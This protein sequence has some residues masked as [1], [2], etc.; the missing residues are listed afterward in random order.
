MP[1]IAPIAAEPCF[2]DSEEDI[3]FGDEVTPPGRESVE[4]VVPVVPIVAPKRPKGR[5]RKPRALQTDAV[6]DEVEIASIVLHKTERKPRIFVGEEIRTTV[7][8]LA[9]LWVT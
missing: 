8:A 4:A 3:L 7:G 1:C 9:Y 2:D 5:P 6:V